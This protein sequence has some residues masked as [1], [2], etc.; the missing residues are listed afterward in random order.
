MPAFFG[1]AGTKSS[2]DSGPVDLHLEKKV[3]TEVPL[4]IPPKD[5][6][7]RI[8][9]ADNLRDHTVY[10]RI[11]NGD[12]SEWGESNFDDQGITF[13]LKGEVLDEMK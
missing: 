8:G 6:D 13:G 2:Q 1:Y 4:D 7:K 5:E 10:Q 3:K 11:C 9:L 12:L